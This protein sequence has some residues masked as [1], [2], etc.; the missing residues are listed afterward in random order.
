ML[1]VNANGLV[2]ILLPKNWLN[3]AARPN[4]PNLLNRYT[5]QP[6]RD[7]CDQSFLLPGNQK[8]HRSQPD[9]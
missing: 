2:F 9:L 1:Y 4:G 3:S 5:F 8:Q 6:R 7:D